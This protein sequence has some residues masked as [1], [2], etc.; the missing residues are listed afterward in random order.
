M[1]NIQKMVR[2]LY[3]LKCQSSIVIFSFFAN[4]LRI[5]SVIA[6]LTVLKL[7]DLKI[8]QSRNIVS[9]CVSQL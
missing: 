5:I 9:I 1:K 8:K 4:N 7:A 3:C 2:S 6:F